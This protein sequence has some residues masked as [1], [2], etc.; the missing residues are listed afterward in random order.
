MTVE[1]IVAEYSQVITVFIRD[2]LSKNLAHPVFCKL[3]P[4][5]TV[6][7]TDLVTEGVSK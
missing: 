2:L 7:T 5:V 3:G 4:E 1:Y 6:V